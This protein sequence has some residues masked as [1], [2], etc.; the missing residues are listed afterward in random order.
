MTG[1]LKIL[2]V[3]DSETDAELIWH[4]IEKNKIA[5]SKVLVDRKDNYI[6]YL[7]DF[8][9]DLIISDYTLP[10]FD[11]MSAL[12]LRNE[13]APLIPFILVT[14]SINEE[15]AVECM[16][17]GADDYI[18]KENLSRLGPAISNSISKLKLAKEKKATE[19]KL[20]KSEMRLQKAQSI[21]L[22]GNWELDLSL[23]IIWASDEAIR[24]YGLKK[25]SHEVPYEHIKSIPLPEYREILD[26]ALDRLLKYNELY[27]AE[28]KIRRA[29]NGAI[30]SIYSKA[31]LVLD[32]DGERVKVIGVIQ[33]ITDRKKTDEALMQSEL[34]FKQI[35]EHS[36]EWIWEVDKNG[37][38]TYSSPIVKNILGYDP[39]E[40]V[41]KKYFYDFFIPEI[42]EEFK[43]AALDAFERKDSFENFINCNL[44]KDG[45]EI[46]L[47][48]SG[49][50]VLDS[51]GNLICYRGV[52]TD[53]TERK[54]AEEAIEQ[55]RRMLRTLIDNLP[56]PIFVV[57]K[58]G[59]KVI[60]NKADVEH[61]GLTSEA[62][63]LGKT[64]IDL[65]PGKIGKRGY[66]DDL[67]VIT[68]GKPI[69]NREEEF[70]SIKGVKRWLQTTKIP[71]QD[72]DGNITGL[73][74]ICHDITQRKENE[75]ELI[76]AKEKAE[77]SDKLK[78]AF[79]HN[80]SHEIRT[81]M[82]AIVGF[83]ALLG[84]PDVDSQT[85]KSYIE[86]IMQSSNH[87]LSIISDIVD[88]SN[89][90]ANLTKTLENEI[91]LN[92]TIKSLCNQFIPIAGEKKIELVCETGLSGS[93]DYILTDSTKLSQILSNLM[94]N[95]IKF[96]DKGHIKLQYKLNDN[97]LEFCVSDTG[98]G[99]SPENHNRIFDRFYQVQSD[100]TRLYEGTGLGL[101]ISKAYVEL[102]GGRIWVTS[103]PGKGTSFFFTIPYKKQVVRTLPVFED[104]VPETF[105]FPQIKTI[106]VAED[107]ESNYKLIRYFLSGS[108]TEILHAFNGKEAVEI[109]LSASNI[110]LILM[111][112]KMPVM[113]GYTAVK[114]IRKKNAAIPIIA[115]TAYADDKEKALEYG[116]SGFISKP[117]DKKGLF[118]VLC[119][120]I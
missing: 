67:K 109:F 22:I 59:R 41:N 113:D 13:F 82:N 60:A 53:I 107:V 106:L 66:A 116:C 20:N 61:I 94:S 114:L 3:E 40:I 77:E 96:T 89:I 117:F 90:E 74:G 69:F 38:Y 85:Q 49:I 75:E 33:D 100:E 32:R 24:I 72:K 34:R 112:I 95:A 15:V 25:E 86:T 64:D 91:S 47:S 99:I 57:D 6:E 14:G 42:R 8:E 76:R 17:A 65:F 9:P 78:T 28:F 84:E 56:D 12:L 18:L 73:V 118:K 81:P 103:E 30:R 43:K 48:T 58:E 105:V 119:E 2:F 10:Q 36:G 21:A 80:I 52:D 79:L 101:S 97:F 50:P 120:F 111:D 68:S 51:S 108:N 5:F 62:E 11:G 19:D 70:I 83:S 102:L 31:E 92:K 87:L 115:Q 4:E 1:K 104:K 29:D 54:R 93:D 7:I 44:H 88:I 63:V 45:R 16:K 35:S 26:E 71:L 98:I 110:D 46:I 55:E 23:G 27:E 39:E 37:L